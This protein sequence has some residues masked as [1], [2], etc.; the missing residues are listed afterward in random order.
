MATYGRTLMALIICCSAIFLRADEEP[1]R[2]DRAE[3][4][5][6]GDAGR[7]DELVPMTVKYDRAMLVVVSKHGAA[8]VRFFDPIELGNKSGNGVVGVSYEWRFLE[9]ELGAAEQTGTGRVFAKL[10][11]GNV[12]DG[13]LG[14]TCGPL[15]LIWAHQN[16][17]SG[18]VRFNPRELAVH[19]VSADY[20]AERK[21][22]FPGASIDLRRFLRQE[23]PVKPT[24]TAGPVLYGSDVLVVRDANDIAT[25]EF[26][27]AFERAKG[28]DQ[29]LHGVPYHFTLVSPEG[30][31][32]E[33]DGEVYETY[34]NDK[35]DE[36]ASQL[37]L[38]AGPLQIT[39]SRGGD[40]LGWI[41]YDP[42]RKLIWCVDKPYAEQLVRAISGDA[43]VAADGD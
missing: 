43:R 33:G 32:T 24:T 18:V 21:K 9:R 12:R 41:Y 26:G 29:K 34:T 15:E 1:P 23:E 36:G 13:L 11:D 19:P 39:W 8:G 28:A 5:Q 16:K 2:Q 17:A 40:D 25:F 22:H 10:V 3:Q 38:E 30:E 37:D 35:Y 20:F 6:P 42:P 14:V 4:D 31:T 27:A 7:Q